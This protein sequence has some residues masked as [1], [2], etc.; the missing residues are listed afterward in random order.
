MIKHFSIAITAILLFTAAAVS[1][2]KIGYL[3]PQDVL[4][5]L[6]EK[7]EV[8]QELNQFLDE[9]EAEFEEEAIGFQSEMA[10]FQQ[11][12]GNLSEA[13]ARR[14]QERLE[15]KNQELEQFQQ[16]IQQ[17]L[18]QRQAN[19]L[20]PLLT[21]INVAIET[22]AEDMELDYVLNEAT[23]EG[24][25]ILIFISPEGENNLDITEQVLN[26]MLN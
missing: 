13:E 18:R 20:E 14:E 9:K 25:R 16:Q 2:P 10:E 5:E 12:Q 24:E 23:G 6:P 15:V 11:Q 3:N 22:V 19:L 7:A 4:D 8:E 1:Q 21:E 26:L 17:E